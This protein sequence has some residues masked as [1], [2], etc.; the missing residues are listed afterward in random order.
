MPGYWDSP[1]HRQGLSQG[2]KK[3][4]TMEKI[5]VRFNE[6]DYEIDHNYSFRHYTIADAKRKRAIRLTCYGDYCFPEKMAIPRKQ[7]F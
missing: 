5:L 6:S 1:D 7:F 4:V 2:S 3:A